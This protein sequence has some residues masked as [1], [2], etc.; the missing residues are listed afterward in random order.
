MSLA[1]VAP[2]YVQRFVDLV[3]RRVG[4]YEFS[5]QWGVLIDQLWVR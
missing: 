4:D 5:P 3:S 2:M 1:P